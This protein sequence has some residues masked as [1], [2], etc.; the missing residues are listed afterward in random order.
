M[1]MVCTRCNAAYE[2]ALHCP[3]CG[4]ALVYHAPS[5]R[6]F[7]Y[8]EL[9]RGW[10]HTDW[11]RF[12]IGVGLAQG[13]FYGLYLLLKSIF[14]AAYGEP[15]NAQTM[16]LMEVSCVQSLQL[17]GLLVG[18]VIA[19]VTRR[20]ALVLGVYI[21]VANSILSYILAQWP[22]QAIN[23]PLF[24]AQPFIQI[25][26][27]AAGCLISSLIWKPLA[28]V[29]LPETPSRMAKRLGAKRPRVLKIFAGP[30]SWVRLTLGVAVGVAGCLVA[31]YALDA[32]L[33]LSDKFSMD[34]YMQESLVLWEL[35]GV[36]LLLGG[37]VAG[38]GTANG[39]KQGLMTGMFSGVVM[40]V[41]MVYRNAKP[42]A[43][44]LSLVLAFTLS[45][46]G[47]WFGGQL[48]PRVVPRKRL[49]GML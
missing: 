23:T 19:G 15:F 16:P 46:L 21:G 28:V 29:T 37:I 26:V 17:F 1:S 11:G 3:T 48:F 20:Q 27:G 25:V 14:V 41:V 10:Q 47:G 7:N 9:A 13:L 44:V 42:E 39:L 22:V 2:Q 18:S 34:E 38:A 24:Y 36:A 33:N 40:N 6:A 45:F 5:K 30:I 12:F 8:A 31:R 35:R 4:N 32:V 43:V 49:D